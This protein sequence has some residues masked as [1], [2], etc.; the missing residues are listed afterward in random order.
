GRCGSGRARRRRA[1]AAGAVPEEVAHLRLGEGGPA[2]RRARHGADAIGAL[3][4]RIEFGVRE[5]EPGA[6]HR[7]LGE[8]VESLGPLRV[9]VVLGAEVGDFGGD[10]TAEPRRIEAGDLSHRRAPR[11]E[12]GP[13]AVRG[14]ADRRHGADP[15]DHN[16]TP[17][18]V[19]LTSVHP[20]ASPRG[21][22]PFDGLARLTPGW[23]PGV[24]GRARL[25]T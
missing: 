24:P 1:E 25:P 20:G 12:P 21:Q 8:A 4:R 10:S 6:R 3:T 14:G 19:H 7:E 2:E 13:E 15:G 5:G 9:E 11:R 23:W 18:V 17:T 22:P 16:A